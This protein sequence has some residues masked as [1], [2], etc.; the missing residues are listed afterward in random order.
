MNQAYLLLDQ[1]QIE[2]LPHRLFE[3][4]CSAPCHPLYQGT[5]YSSLNEVSPVLVEVSPHS[6][7]ADT[8]AREWRETAGLWLESDAGQ[9]AVLKHAR[10]LVHA[11]IEGA[12][13][14]FFRYY[15]PRI[16]ALWLPDLPGAERD[17]LM[18]PIRLIRLPHTQIHQQN[19]AQA[20]AQ[21][22]HTP[23]L[24][25][26]AEQL[27][28]LSTSKRQHISQQLIEHA[29]QYFPQCV[30]GM[31]PA[32][33]QQWATHCQHRAQQYGFSAVNEVFLWARFHAELG[34][35]FPEDASH[36]R[37]RQLLAEP[38]VSPEQ[39]LNNMNAELTHQLLTH[40]EFSV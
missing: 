29:Q 37:Y 17:R 40:K 38:G 16:M 28:Q 19:P 33:Q 6:P 12:V 5:A 7:L 3:L 8:F 31:A 4:G 22:A 15:D 39:R 1:A 20:V 30:Q 24:Q 9:D 2:N 23:W 36:A 14:V 18:G 27:A 21:Y 13:T 10:S 32:A 11:R 34:A 26:G 25:L 35:E